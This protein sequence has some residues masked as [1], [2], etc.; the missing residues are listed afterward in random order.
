M[1]AMAIVDYAKPLEL[2]D[3]PEPE[4]KPGYVL[5]RIL[6]CGVCF[7]DYKTAK[8]LMPY[9][10]TLPL[11]H[12][13]GHEICGEA[14]EAGSETGWQVGDRVVAYHYW[15]CGRCPYCRKGQENLCHNLV[16]WTGF[17]HPG[18]FEEYLAVPADRLLR[19]P[20]GISPE[21]A[22]P[23]T[24]ASGTAYRA[25]LSRGRVQAGETVV[26]LGLGGVG[27]QAIQLAQL[28]G[29]QT[30]G[31]D[32][33]GRKLEA[34]Q[35]FDVA[36]VALGDEEARALIGQKTD[37]LGADL[38]INTVSHPAAFELAAQLVRRGGRIVAVGYAAGQYAQFET[39]SLVLNEI[40][41]IGVRYALRY[42]LERVLS[43]FA[44]GKV[45]AIVDD[46]LPL[47]EA[48]EALR[49]LEAGQVVGRTVLRVSQ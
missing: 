21:S 20:E 2:I 36:G 16:G 39:A 8:G 35:Q 24:C 29:A 34:A 30:L 41:I 26:I 1:R 48:N 43:L 23:A 4:L 27:L 18:G 31:V 49:R 32:V 40:E 22:A 7:S 38:I 10:S 14:V 28:A 47:A 17:T 15:S 9:S 3:L 6:A 42:E 44:A 45:K 19:V 5:L 37:D 33:D 11:P 13:P 25:L 46:V 12:V